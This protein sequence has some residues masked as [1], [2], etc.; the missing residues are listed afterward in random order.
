M[1]LLK[2]LKF[3]LELG[4]LVEFEFNSRGSLE[5]PYLI[6]DGSSAN[7]K[8]IRASYLGYGPDAR[9]ARAWG[10]Q[11]KDISF[12]ERERETERDYVVL[13]SMATLERFPPVE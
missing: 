2:V 10:V 1:P 3:S 12:S 4:D 13:E 5:T 8:M 9:V 7:F 11:F 6:S